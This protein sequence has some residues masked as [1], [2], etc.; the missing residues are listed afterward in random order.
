MS[1]GERCRWGG[2]DCADLDGGSGTSSTISARKERVELLATACFTWPGSSV[3]PEHR[4]LDPRSKSARN[5]SNARLRRTGAA[6]LIL[7]TSSSDCMIRLILVGKTFVFSDVV[8]GGWWEASMFSASTVN[9]AASACPSSCFTSI[10]E[11]TMPSMNTP[12]HR[13]MNTPHYPSMNTPH[14]PSMETP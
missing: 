7:P 11:G 6:A 8:H 9:S 10:L 5:S 1:R 3:R 4:L 13:L 12:H 14:Y 2:G